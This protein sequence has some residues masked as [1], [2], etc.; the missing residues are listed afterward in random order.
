M[1]ARW[2]AAAPVKLGAVRVGD[3][4]VPLPVGAGPAEM[5]A[6]VADAT[7]ERARTMIAEN[8]ILRLVGFV[9]VVKRR[10]RGGIK[11]YRVEQRVC[12]RVYI[13]N[14]TASVGLRLG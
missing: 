7:A 8:C 12:L 14:W 2:V 1:T 4:R 10:C 13:E 3:T 5:V 6:V 9:E 11:R